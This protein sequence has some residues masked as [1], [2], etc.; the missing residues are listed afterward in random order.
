MIVKP[1][2]TEL[3]GVIVALIT[4]FTDDGSAIDEGRLEAHINRMLDAGVHGLLP[5]GSTGEF[6][7]L[8]TSERKQLLEL[9]VKYAN[10]RAPVVAG[11]GCLNTK[12]D[13]EMA[14]HAAQAGASAVMVV[15]PFYDAVNYQELRG[16]MQEIHSASGL[17]IVYYN[18]PGASGTR[19]SPEEIAGL[20]DV[21]VKY[22]K[23][24]SGD[25]PALTEL[26]FGHADK[27]TTF[28]GWD[29]LTFYGM[30]AG[31]KGSVWGATNVIPE[32]SVE[33]WNTLAVKKDIEK[34]RQL[35][36]QIWPICA[37]LEKGNYAAAVKTSLELQGYPTGGV[38]K[39]F[40]LLT[41]EPQAELKRV[42]GSAGCL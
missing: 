23:D 26:I 16:L 38:R 25:G 15:P 2:T 17:P 20:S 40:N 4:P 27:I 33:L 31:C 30:A 36:K 28:N 22:L 1:D 42:L 41:G 21:G 37:T 39:P 29:T 34:A 11:I 13:V 5:G 32:L 19:L 18:I 24:T 10:G 8:T 6:T 35:W 9:V 14:Q 3:G 7:A 12:D